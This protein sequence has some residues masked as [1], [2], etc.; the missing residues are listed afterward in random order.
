MDSDR[1][2]RGLDVMRA[3]HGPNVETTLNNFFEGV[4]PEFGRYIV[5]SGYGDVYGRQGLPLRERELLTV[6]LLAGLGVEADQLAVHLRGAL[7]LG[8]LPSEVVEA[9]FSVAVYAGH[10]RAVTALKVVREVF[11]ELGVTGDSLD[12]GRSHD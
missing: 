12:A 10:P 8:V 1:Y 11:N 4:S 6:A 2:T 3:M 7:A 5:E 9:M